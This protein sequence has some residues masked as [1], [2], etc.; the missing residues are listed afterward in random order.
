MT[1]ALA[2]DIAYFIYRVHMLGSRCLL[3]C[4]VLKGCGIY[5]IGILGGWY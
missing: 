2:G 4:H 1:L 5:M 3:D